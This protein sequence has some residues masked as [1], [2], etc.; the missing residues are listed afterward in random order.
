MYWIALVVAIGFLVMFVLAGKQVPPPDTASLLKPFYKIALY[1]Y[2]KLWNRIP[3]VFS[4]TQVERDLV[5]LHPGEAREYLKTE[6][7]GKKTAICLA[8]L[9]VGTVFGAAAKFSAMGEIVLREDGTVARGSYREGAQEID[10]ETDYGQQQMGFQVEVEPKRLTKEE[11]ERLFED[12]IEKL[13]EYVLGSNDSLQNVSYDLNLREK[14]DDFP[15]SIEWESD[16]PGRISDSGQIFSLEEETEVTFCFRLTYGAWERNGELAVILKPPPLAEE[17]LLHMELREALRE[18][19]NGSLNQDE[20]QLPS[21]WRGE[22]IRW[23]QVVEDNSLILWAVALVTAVAAFLFLDRDLHGQLE[24]RRKILRREYPEI[25][26]K[27]VLFVG[28]GMTIRGAFQKIAGDYEAKRSEGGRSSP[29]YEEILY[30]CRELRSGISEGLCY[31]HLGK[32]AGLQEYIRLSAL[33][34]QNLKRG[35]STLLERLRDEAEKAAQERL[36]ES[37]KMGEEA[38]TKLLVPM[39]LMLAVVMV[40]IMIPAFSNM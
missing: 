8:I 12:L 17:D 1:L 7:Y 16:N 2:K 23:R 22:R 39:M 27:L 33:L 4:S 11:A 30:T 6:Y 5:N 20:W 34:A 29:A 14:Y 19:Q 31:E 15:M 26:H 25:V 35:S 10:V 36:Q 37:R 21:E 40:I 28:A 38:G 18:S 24:K 13:P 3:G 9:F 32:R